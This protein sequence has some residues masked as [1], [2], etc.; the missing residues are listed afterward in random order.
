MNA[1][2]YVAPDIL[3]R[4][5]KV[6]LLPNEGTF[7]RWPQEPAVEVATPG[8]EAPD[9]AFLRISEELARALYEGLAE[10]F[11]HTGHDMRALRN[12][13]DAERR[14]V[15]QFISHLTKQP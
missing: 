12:D 13:Y 10:H 14:R 9:D 11:G 7:L 8:T 3:A 15:D 6:A 2:A 5:V 1:R 4:G